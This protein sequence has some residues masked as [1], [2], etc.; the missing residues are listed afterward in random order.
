MEMN[1]TEFAEWL[2]V[3]LAQYNRWENQKQQPEINT[4]FR[5]AKKIGCKV[6]DLFDYE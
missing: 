1:Q 2:G 5:L 6:D 3:K 4:S